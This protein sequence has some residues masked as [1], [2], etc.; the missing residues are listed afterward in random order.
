MSPIHRIICSRLSIWLFLCRYSA[1]AE[2]AFCTWSTALRGRIEA[3]VGDGVESL[4][5]DDGAEDNVAIRVQAVAPLKGAKSAQG[6]KICTLRGQNRAGLHITRARDP[7]LRSVSY[8]SL[9]IQSGIAE[10]DLT[11]LTEAE[12]E[13]RRGQLA[14]LVADL[15]GAMRRPM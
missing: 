13:E 14:G 1:Y 11:E 9:K 4:E 2:S 15:A 6:G 5:L 10:S 12:R 3:F 7:D 8:P